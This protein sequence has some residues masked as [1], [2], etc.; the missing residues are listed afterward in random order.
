MPHGIIN[1]ADHISRF[2]CG[3]SLYKLDEQLHLHEFAALEIRQIARNIDLDI[4]VR[5]KPFRDDKEEGVIHDLESDD[6]G[7]KQS[8]TI[9]SEF[10]GGLGEEDEDVQ[11]DVEGNPTVRRRA[12]FILNLNE[13]RA[14]LKRDR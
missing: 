1:L 7:L 5:K 12:L 10:V 11:E 2:V 8:N 13:C 3:R 14:L 9:R 6:D 4:L